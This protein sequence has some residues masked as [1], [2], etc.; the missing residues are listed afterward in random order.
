MRALI[1][2]GVHTWPCAVSYNLDEVLQTVAPDAVMM[3][4]VQRAFKES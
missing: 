4:R 3:L 2:V 1:P